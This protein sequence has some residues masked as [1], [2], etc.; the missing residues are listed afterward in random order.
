MKFFYISFVIFLSL[1]ML[2]VDAEKNIEVDEI[3][4]MHG[5]K[6]QNYSESIAKNIDRGY[7]E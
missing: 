2:F 6:H 5:V 1:Q 7:F 4:E 3:I